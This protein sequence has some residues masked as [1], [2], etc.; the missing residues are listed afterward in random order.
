MSETMGPRDPGCLGRR[1][2]SRG[3]WAL[4]AL[5]PQGPCDPGPHGLG[6]LSACMSTYYW[7]NVSINTMGTSELPRQLDKMVDRIVGSQT[8]QLDI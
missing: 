6:H 2:G 8:S 4:G 7:I 3:P 1:N 5:A